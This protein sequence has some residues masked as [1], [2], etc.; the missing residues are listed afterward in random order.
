MAKFEVT[1][2]NQQVRQKVQDGEHH[3]HFTDEWADFRYVDI[4]AEN[5]DHVRARIEDRYP[6]K[7]GFVIDSILKQD[8]SKFE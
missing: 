7:Q 4:R 1:I 2:F 6:A 8:A 3:E 5:E